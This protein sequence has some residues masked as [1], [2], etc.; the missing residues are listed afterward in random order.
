MKDMNNKITKR[1]VMGLS[2]IICPLS[3]SMMFTS[4]ADMLETS[5]DLVE[6]HGLRL[7]RDGHREQTAVHCRPYG[8]SR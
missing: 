5:S 2:F 4:C 6:C 1:L 8:H 3:F 7:Q